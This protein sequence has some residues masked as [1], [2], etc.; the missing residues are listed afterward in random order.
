[1]AWVFRGY[2]LVCHTEIKD[3]ICC[4]ISFSLQVVLSLAIPAG[5]NVLLRTS[6]LPLT[7]P[8]PLWPACVVLCGNDPTTD[9]PKLS[10]IFR[11]KHSRPGSWAAISFA[12]FACEEAACLWGMEAGFW[13]GLS[14]FWSGYLLKR[15]SP[16]IVW[17]TILGCWPSLFAH[18]STK[19]SEWGISGT[20]KKLYFLRTAPPLA[21]RAS[22]GSKGGVSKIGWNANNGQ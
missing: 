16:G 7:W 19:L 18:W 11:W 17:R 20:G 2:I 15:I 10:S 1:M 3:F 14:Y 22:T 13:L 6:P 5:A 4:S 8:G 9:W 12:A 21:K